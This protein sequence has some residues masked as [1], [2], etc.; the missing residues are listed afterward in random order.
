MF[1][2]LILEVLTIGSRKMVKGVVGFDLCWSE[3]QEKFGKGDDWL[4]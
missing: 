2:L 3:S 1:D 4:L